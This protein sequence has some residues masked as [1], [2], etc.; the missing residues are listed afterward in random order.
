MK[1]E[2]YVMLTKEQKAEIVSKY[3]RNKNDTGLPEVQIAILTQE[4]NNATEHLQT[5]KKDITSRRSLLKNVAQRKHLLSYL[6][7]KD[8]ERYKAIIEALKIR[9]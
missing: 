8:F 9:K 7:N 3:G 4:I 1:G 5:H 6:A 2:Y